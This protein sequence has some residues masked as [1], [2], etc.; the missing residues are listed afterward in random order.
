LTAHTLCDRG[1]ALTRKGRTPARPRLVLATT[2]LA[3]S[4]AFIDGSVVN[5]GLPAIGHSLKGSTAS[6]SWV[7][8]AYLLP[9]SAL[10]LFGG[11]LGDRFGR[12]RLLNIGVGVF[13]ASSIACAMSP[14]LLWLCL[15]RALQGIGAALLLPNSLAILGDSFEGQARGRAVGVWSATGAMMGAVGP[16]LGGWLIDK[17]GWPAIFLI[18]PLLAAAAFVLA[19][20]SVRDDSGDVR[21]A[22]LDV[23]GAALATAALAAL[24]WALT[25]GSGAHGWTSAV[26]AVAAA[27]VILGGVFLWTERRLGE[28]AMTPLALFGSRQMTALN[29]MTFLLYGALGGYLLLLPYVLIDGLSYSALAAGAALLPFPIVV[30]LVS[31]VAGS[32]AGRIGP[33][34]PLIAGCLLVTAGL[35][36]CLLIA[37][38]AGYWTGVAPGVLATGLGMAFA[39]APLT[40]AVL[41]SVDERHT[42]AASGLNS[43]VSRIGG[44]VVVALIGSVLASRGAALIHGFRLA[45]VAGAVIAAAAAACSAMVKGGPSKPAA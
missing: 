22:R 33:R 17:V 16:V 37:P 11:A 18:N 1:I 14:S 29:L 13:A 31:P 40:T 3:S 15:A 25:T 19:I 27:G 35:L 5:V 24:T 36:A 2:I 45:A 4:L 8:N 38:G 39:A 44:V 7:I 41:G 6:L 34:I 12:R 21:D 43:A 9:L 20:I 42:G 32:V 28:H 23:A 26:F 30:S 10:I